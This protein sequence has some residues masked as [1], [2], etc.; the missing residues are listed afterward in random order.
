MIPVCDLQVQYLQLKKEI[1]EAMQRVAASGT[2]ILGPE[3][4]ALEG[5]IARYC[6]CACAVGVNS[7]TDALH[8][9]LR[10]LR[11]GAGDEVITTPFTFIATTEAIGMVGATTVFVD[12]DPQTFNMD[13]AA[14]EAAITPRTRAILPVHLYGQPCDMT[15]IMATARQ[16]GLYV[17]EDCAQS[18]GAMLNGTATGLYGE[19]RPA[20]VFSPAKIQAPSETAAWSLPTMPNWRL[21]WKCCGGMGER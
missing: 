13:P 6:G 20:L 4:K 5:E 12:I 11:I 16:H 18:I 21:A 1:D 19:H 2:Y 10:A 17:V 14:L 8:L 7:G 15:A 3:V 9:A